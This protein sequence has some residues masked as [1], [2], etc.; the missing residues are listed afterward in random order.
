MARR[1]LLRF[2]PSVLL[3]HALAILALAHVHY[4]GWCPKAQAWPWYE[5]GIALAVWPLCILFI[6]GFLKPTFSAL[7]NDQCRP[8]LLIALGL[9]LGISA[10]WSGILET[11]LWLF[12]P[13]VGAVLGVALALSRWLVVTAVVA[14]L[15]SA[16]VRTIRATTVRER[17]IEDRSLTVAARIEPIPDRS[18][19]VA[20]RMIGIILFLIAINAFAV[21]YVQQERIVYYWDYMVYWTKTVELA[22]A[23]KTESPGDVL[24]GLR[25]ATQGDDYGPMPAVMPALIAT[26]FGDSRLVYILAVANL[27]LVGLGLAS[28]LF[29]RRILPSSPT[30]STTVPLLMVL[31]CPV[32]WLPLLRGYLDIG[33]AA[34]AV[35]VLLAY[36]SKPAGELGWPKAIQLALLLVALTLFRRWYSFF[37]VAFF[38]IAGMDTGLVAI[39]GLLRFGFREAFRRAAP[40]GLAGLWAFALLFTVAGGWVIRAATTNYADDY[41]AYKSLDPL[42]ERAWLIVENCGPGYFAAALLGLIVSL[43]YRELRRPAL[44]IAGMVPVM[45]VHFLKTQDPGPHHYYLFLPALVLLPSLAGVRFLYLLS[46]YARLPLLMLAALIGTISMYVMFD[47]HG[48][49]YHEDLRP[50]VSRLHSPPLTRHDLPELIRLMKAADEATPDGGTVVVASSSLALSPTTLQTA[51]RSLGEPI[52][53]R[54]K[55]RLTPEVDRVSSFPEGFFQAD[56]I[57]VVDPPQW[58]LRP[59]EQ[60]VIVITAESLLQN[61]EIGKAFDRLPGEYRLFDPQRGQDVIAFIYRRARPI[62]KADFEEYVAKLKAAHPTRTRLSEPPPGLERYLEWTK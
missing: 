3:A 19:T 9:G 5:L 44:V 37:V 26:L 14:G 41:F 39:K 47:P 52:I 13:N 23:M 21:W 53:D 60:Q 61:R 45:T 59:E 55:V 25:R 18:L 24:D 50:A 49:K 15:L 30:L 48:M 22:E 36:L 1:W 46:M 42:H 43:C 34:I 33:G 11:T 58:H 28:V 6:N 57:V 32:A 40:L 27:Y 31:L 54:R 35:L 17:L 51:D 10:W 29:V 4:S 62:P 2:G 12:A 56:V 20:A 8:F 7:P 16:T 38:L